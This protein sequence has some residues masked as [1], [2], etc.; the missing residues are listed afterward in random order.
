MDKAL[1]GMERER[2]EKRIKKSILFAVCPLLLFSTLLRKDLLWNISNGR[3]QSLSAV[4]SM[5]DSFPTPRPNFLLL[6]SRQREGEGARDE[7]NVRP[8]AADCVRGGEQSPSHLEPSIPIDST[9]LK[10]KAE[11]RRSR[12]RRELETC[13]VPKRGFRLLGSFHVIFR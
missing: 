9:A 12:R 13:P 6:L 8:F 7:T 10:E 1:T 2:E 5:L 4:F 11:K 3:S